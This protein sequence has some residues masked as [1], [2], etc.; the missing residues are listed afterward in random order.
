M[1]RLELVYTKEVV[2]VKSVDG[3]LCGL[4]RAVVPN[5]QVETP[6]G[7]RKMNLVGR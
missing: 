6:Q 2:P 5:P 3:V 4:S 7:G 1:S